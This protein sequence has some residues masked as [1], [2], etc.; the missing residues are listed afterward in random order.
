[1]SRA[2][3]WAHSVQQIMLDRPSFSTLLEDVGGAQEAKEKEIAFVAAVKGVPYIQ[4]RG[5]LLS[6]AQALELMEW[7][8]SVLND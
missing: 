3:N 2:E 6:K 1:M 4:L 8:R 7:L 5:G